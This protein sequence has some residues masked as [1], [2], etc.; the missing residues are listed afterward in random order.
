MRDQLRPWA[1][2]LIVLL[3]FNRNTQEVMTRF[4]EMSPTPMSKYLSM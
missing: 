3:C 4:K 2:R 1:A